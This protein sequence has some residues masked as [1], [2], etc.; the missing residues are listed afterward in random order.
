M[1]QFKAHYQ[2]DRHDL[3]LLITSRGGGKELNTLS[4]SIHGF[5]FS[6]TCFDAFELD[7]LSQYEETRAQFHLLKWNA[8]HNPDRCFCDLQRYKMDVELPICVCGPTGSPIPGACLRLSF[9]LLPH[10]P[11]KTQSIITYNRQR[12]FRDDVLCT[13]F[14]MNIGSDV[15]ESG[16][17]DL[18][19]EYALLELYRKLPPKY[20]LKCCFTCQYSDYSPYGSDD[21]GTM[22]CYADNKEKYLSVN[23]KDDYFQ[24]LEA[25]SYSL[26]QETD[27]CAAFEP[28]ITCG[29]YRGFL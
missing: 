10:S 17:K 21:F 6:G 7:D 28:R 25:L 22:L 8:P 5:A 2:D 15:Y 18:C 27:L 14:Q 4:F 3:D 19:F 13:R 24:Y 11:A 12:V 26:R 9:Q 23:N 29:G 16:R 20:R 1:K